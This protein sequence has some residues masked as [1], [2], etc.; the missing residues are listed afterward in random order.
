[1]FKRR[2][3]MEVN[4][5]GTS[6]YLKGR[7]V[8]PLLRCRFLSNKAKCFGKNRQTQW[9]ERSLFRRSACKWSLP[10]LILQ[11]CHSLWSS[12]NKLLKRSIAWRVRR[13]V[14]KRLL[15]KRTGLLVNNSETIFIASVCRWYYR[16]LEFLEGEAALFASGLLLKIEGR[17][18]SYGSPAAV[19][20]L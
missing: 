15:L 20:F 16:A 3:V 12:N 4:L 17:R 9:T 7:E 5:R 6:N 2:Q 11:L 14:L 19:A 8:R 1:M 10:V 13:E 18:W